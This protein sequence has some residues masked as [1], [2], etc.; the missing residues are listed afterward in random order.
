MKP[1]YTVRWMIR[2]DMPEVLAAERFNADR[3]SAEKYEWLLHDRTVIGLV[4]TD[5]YGDAV[6]AG[7]YKLDTG[8]LKLLRLVTRPSMRR[9]GVARAII[10]NIRLKLSSHRQNTL[11]AWASEEDLGTQLFFKQSG[12]TATR[13]KEGRIR[14]VAGPL[15]YV[16]PTVYSDSYAE[17]AYVG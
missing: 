2:R 7:V 13:L 9:Q 5:H 11:V 15:D 3:W 6:G 1:N 17:F 8:K 14:F 12:F 4:A 16:A 10:E